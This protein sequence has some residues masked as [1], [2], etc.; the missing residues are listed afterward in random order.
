LRSQPPPTIIAPADGAEAK[1]WQGGG[2]MRRTIRIVLVLQLVLLAGCTSFSGVKP[3]YPKVGDPDSPQMVESLQPTFQWESHPDAETYDF[4]ITDPKAGS[5]ADGTLKPV[6][7]R[8][9]LTGTKHRVEEPLTPNT[10]YFWSVRTRRGS[11]VSPW[12][13]YNYSVETGVHTRTATNQ[14]FRF[15]TP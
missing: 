11:N 8:E 5:F 1:P 7:Y 6:Y 9:A 10:V 15:K 12:S 2:A 3:V 4:I 13:R 14:P